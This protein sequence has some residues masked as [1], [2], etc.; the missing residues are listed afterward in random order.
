MPSQVI[1]RGSTAPKMSSP[2]ADCSAKHQLPL[3]VVFFW[4]EQFVLVCDVA[5]LAGLL[6]SQMGCRDW[7][8]PAVFLHWHVVSWALLLSR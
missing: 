3:S 7:A 8:T 6:A 4:V 5:H 2:K 1:G